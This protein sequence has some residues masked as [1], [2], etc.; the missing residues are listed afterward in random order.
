MGG[1]RLDLG[2]P[3]QAAAQ[4]EAALKLVRPNPRPVAFAALG[5]AYGL[6]GRRA[7]ALKVLAEME[8]A[9]KN[10][11]ISPYCLALVY[12]GVGRMDEAFRLLDQALEQRTP[13][14]IISPRTIPA[15]SASGE[16]PGGSRS[17]SASGG[18]YGCLPAPPTRI[19]SPGGV[20]ILQSD[21]SDTGTLAGNGLRGDH[22]SLRGCM[23]LS[24][25]LRARPRALEQK[26]LPDTHSAAMP[27]S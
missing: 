13:Y 2:Q 14:L 8:Q 25:R 20:A 19:R 11:Y 15:P 7:D 3:G 24:S 4:F 16:T 10:R 26:V 5:L 6:A 9:S 18:R 1:A 23:L 22:D 21:R 12:S 17:W 27:D